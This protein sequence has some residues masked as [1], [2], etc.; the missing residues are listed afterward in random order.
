[1]SAPAVLTTAPAP[2]LG[3]PL[4]PRPTLSVRPALLWLA[5]IAW[6][7]SADAADHCPA[8]PAAPVAVAPRGDQ[9]PA[10]TRIDM[11]SRGATV[12]DAGAAELQGPVE[13]HQ[14]DRSLTAEAATYDPVAQS[15]DVIGNVEYHDPLLTLAGEAGTWSANGGGHF[16]HGTFE[17]PSRP[18]RGRA[19][20]IVLKADGRLELTGVEYTACPAGQT[21][22][23]LRAQ[24]IDIDQTSQQG[25]G[26]NVRLEFKGLPLFYL[27]VV[28]V[29]VGD[30]RKSGF[31]FPVIGQSSRNGFEVAAPWYWNIAPSYDAT[32]TPGYLSKRGATFGTEF[33]FL[34]AGSR[35][36]FHSDWVPHDTSAGRDRSYLRFVERSDITE[37]LRFDTNL[38]YASDP[39]YFED[40]GLGPEGTSVTYLSRVARLT[41]LDS[42]WRAVGLV[43][44]FQTI[45]QAIALTDRP[46]TRAPQL[47]VQGHWNDASGLGFRVNGEAVEFIRDTGIDGMRFGVEPTAS[48]AWRAPAGFV[49][50]SVGWHTTRYSLRNSGG[51]AS[52]PSVSAPIATLDAG[53]NFERASAGRL[54]TLEPRVLYTYIPYRD[55][56]ALPI[57]D[58]G[59]P[60]LNLIQLFRTQRYVG[61][62]RLGDANQVALGATT[63]LVDLAS[64]RQLLSATLGQI[65]Y[66]QPPRVRLPG[67]PV[68]P[69]SSSDL[70]GQLALTAYKHWTVQL[71]EE[72]NPHAQNSARS[73]IRLQYQPEANK[74]AN[75]GYRFRRGL[76]EQVEGS[77]AWPIADAWNVY[78]R[79]VYSLRDKTAIE[80]FGGFEYKACCWR[81]R[82]VARR[83]VSSRTGTRDTGVS[84]QLELNGLSSVGEKAN[85]FLERS[86]RG[87]SATPD[88][89]G[90]P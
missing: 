83:Y 51:G 61:G 80:S 3:D 43:E 31:L 22:W 5:G 23:L 86:I 17:L 82:L 46:Y 79:H 7:S 65:Y 27:P 56:S 20:A 69:G 73:E 71:G 38:G 15:F 26:R 36:E 78:A 72:W 63:R 12:T 49:V 77:A 42:H 76:L 35:G 10:A 89:N 58:T 13:V 37:R 87:Y 33:R 74:V 54:Q 84:L 34:T 32:L 40:F 70:I 2:T 60:D 62:D 14:G 6:L 28:S 24:R 88:I 48:Y 67:E 50:P 44:Q 1:M 39:A 64:G 66:F 57:F 30:A 47:L 41:Y 68:L 59:L 45:N 25:F 18:A 85:A 52:A 29:P 75:L 11:T 19:D 4:L 55:Q 21:A 90:P 81:I 16:A 53:L 9:G 8:P